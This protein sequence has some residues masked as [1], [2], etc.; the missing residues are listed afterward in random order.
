MSINP[1]ELTAYFNAAIGV[2]ALK[3]HVPVTQLTILPQEDWRNR[4]K[5]GNLEEY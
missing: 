5:L 1:I 4:P 2:T 3:L